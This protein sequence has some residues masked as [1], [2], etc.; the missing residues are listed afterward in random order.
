MTA[1][2]PTIPPA[3]SYH[4]WLGSGWYHWGAPF[5]SGLIFMTPPWPGMNSFSMPRSRWLSLVRGMVE[6]R[7]PPTL[8]FHFVP[9]IPAL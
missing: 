7:S 9:N 5:D 6:F 4:F 1:G 8:K 2:E 3:H